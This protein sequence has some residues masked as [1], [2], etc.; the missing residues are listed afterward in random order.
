MA[1]ELKHD[2]ESL[3]KRIAGLSSERRKLLSK[4]FEGE[5]R[6]ASSLPQIPQREESDAFPLSYAQQ[7]LWFLDQLAPGNT[8]YNVFGNIRLTVPI[9][10]EVLERTFNEVVRR[11]EALRT[12]FSVIDSEPV[13]LIADELKLPLPVID[14]RHLPANERESEALRL[15]TEE[16]QRP[17]DLSQGP[18]VR[19]TLLKLSEREHILLL[20]M[21]H[22]ISDGWSMG[23]FSE[24]LMQLYTAFALGRPSPLK[25]LAIQYA[26]FAVWQRE[27][28]QGSVLD[29]QLQYW[30][31]QLADLP[32]LQLPTDRVRPPVQSYRGAHHWLKLSPEVCEGLRSLSQREGATLFMTL[33]AAFKVLLW[34]YTGQG[35]I[36]VG[37]YIAGRNRAEIESLI[38]FFVNTLVLRTEIKG[39]E[40]FRQLLGRVREVA[41]GAYAHQDLPFE[42]LVEELQPDRDL[43]RNPLFQV[44]FQLLNTPSMKQHSTA[45][46]E[47]ALGVHVGTTAFDIS[48][49][50]RET[51][52]GIEGLIGYNT[53]LFDGSTI[54]RMAGHYQHL[55]TAILAHTEASLWSLPLVSNEEAGQL[56][57]QWDRTEYPSDV[58]LHELFT[59]QVARTPTAVALVHGEE[60]VTYEQLDKRTNQLAR[61]LRT[62]GVCEESLVGI[63]MP[64]SVEMV[65]GLLGVLKAGGAYVPLD[66][67]YPREWRQLMIDDAGLKVILTHEAVRDALADCGA[68]VVCVDSEQEQITRELEPEVECEITADNLAYVIY[69]SGSTGIPKGVLGLHRGALNRFHWMWKTYPFAAN[70]VCCQ[71]TAV[72]FVDS[73]WECL[74]PL[75]QGVPTF[76]VTDDVL[77]DTVRLVEA[78]S[79]RQVTRIVLVPSLLRAL[80]DTNI[81]LHDQLPRLRYWIVSGEAFP[82]EL[83]NRF[84]ER[85]PQGLLLNLYGSSE[86]AADATW[87]DT[88]AKLSPS[89]VPIGRPIANTR[90]YVVDAQ[91]QPV[92]IG[93]PGELLIGGDGLAR[94]YLHRPAL[95][96][97]KF[98]PDSFSALA[99]ARLYRTG[100]LVRYLADG[101]IEF[102]GRIDQQVKIRGFRVE[103]GEI[104]A[105][106]SAHALVKEAVVVAQG[107]TAA[108]GERL[109][110][111]V[112]RREGAEALAL[113]PGELRSHLGGKLPEYMLPSLYLFLEVLPLLPN[114]K[115]NRRALPAPDLQRAQMEEAYLGPRTPVEEVLAGIWAEVLGIDQV[116]V[117][118]NFFTQLG[119]HSLLATQLI[120]RVRNTFHIE[121]PLQRLFESP[122]VAGLAYWI[123]TLKDSDKVREAPITRVPRGQRRVK[124][125][126]QGV[127]E[128]LEDSHQPL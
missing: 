24:E 21:H 31:Q 121:L 99:G 59:E 44:T 6:S 95:T 107:A 41:M 81:D 100:D 111:Y 14:L 4:L 76:I 118:D 127:L 94:G 60:Q 45:E 74:G 65:V 68:R 39:E 82:L 102:L 12:T 89:C 38:G 34:R 1:S 11:H 84:R 51:P 113:S 83:F 78:L 69:T 49:D 97:E 19:T 114:G 112:V 57:M 86:V 93:V 2:S 58:C 105:V 26:D 108:G 75:L 106:L 32:V 88:R 37:S 23:V 16:A 3:K 96:A 87:Y 52:S 29:E 104:E 5:K 124:L 46:D 103:L 126:S 98:I 22:I 42:M 10:V 85:V 67:S 120:S 55:L 62:L 50:L 54:E 7:R 109:L 47:S 116:G 53:D 61:Y 25:E 63:C 36:V 110:A 71:K 56:L 18:L 80:L 90:A 9:N 128:Y 66:P 79:S 15:A 77:K 117:H 8:F 13:Q 123:E 17:F 33:L 72:S 30:K 91:L 35:E 70:E 125:S 64:R 92:P 119:G 101:D 122:T 73:V 43:S 27:W 28:L 48:V 20:T 115:V 40:S